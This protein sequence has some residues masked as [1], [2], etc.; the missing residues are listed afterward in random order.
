[1]GR[2]GHFA[3]LAAHAGFIALCFVNT[4]GSGVLAAPFGGID[5]RL[6]ANPLAVGIPNAAGSPI[7]LDISTCAIAEGKI[8]VALN[9]GES[10]PGGCLID[11]TGRPTND[12]E[13]FYGDPPGAILPFGGHKGFGLSLAVDILAGALTGG[14]C[15]RA[16]VDR[17]EQ[18]MLI[19]ALDPA[20]FVPR[21]GFGG[22]VARFIAYVRTSRTTAPGVE[23]LMPGEPEQR[24]RLQRRK[25]GI[26]IDENTWRQL[27]ESCQSLGVPDEFYLRFSVEHKSN[28]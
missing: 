23:I 19:L 27:V 20:R 16:G 10:V 28:P 12:P 21:D 4:T 15:T 24:S 8:R 17:L 22:E 11:H 14:G 9:K 2:I 5:R 26:E 13:V 18:G 25:H 1:L 3:E 6:S 7:V